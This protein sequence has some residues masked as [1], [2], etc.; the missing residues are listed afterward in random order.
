M[1]SKKYLQSEIDRL[2]FVARNNHEAFNRLLDKY[3]ALVDKLE[4]IV[5]EEKV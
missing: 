4:T 2:Q 3:H 1:P 5:R